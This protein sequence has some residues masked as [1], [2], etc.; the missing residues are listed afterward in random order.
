MFT[1]FCVS[2]RRQKLHH[3]FVN[4]RAYGMQANQPCEWFRSILPGTGLADETAEAARRGCGAY[5][6]ERRHH[7]QLVRDQSGDQRSK[8][9]AI[10]ADFDGAVQ[11]L[12]QLQWN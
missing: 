1:K 8:W 3:L 9:V 5:A 11:S 10:D 2:G 6:L 7:D 4:R 12:F